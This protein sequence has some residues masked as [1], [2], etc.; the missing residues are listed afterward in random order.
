MRNAIAGISLAALAIC[1]VVAAQSGPSTGADE[2]A[3]KV[4]VELAAARK[5]PP[6]LD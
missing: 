1:G 5:L 4:R 3:A 2:L 6:S